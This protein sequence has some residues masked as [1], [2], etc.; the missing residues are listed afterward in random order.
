MEVTAVVTRI[1]RNVIRDVLVRFPDNELRLVKEIPRY[2]FTKA[3]LD[4]LFRGEI[5]FPVRESFATHFI[6][7]QQ[8]K[9]N[10]RKF[11]ANSSCWLILRN[12]NNQIP[13]WL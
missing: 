10:A 3:E 7:A 8:G 1:V 2:C 9:F 11:C 6:G 13:V 12:A 5:V 4:Q